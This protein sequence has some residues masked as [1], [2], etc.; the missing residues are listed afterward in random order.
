MVTDWHLMKDFDTD[1]YFFILDGSCC[2][3]IIFRK[4]FCPVVTCMKQLGYKSAK[5]Q[6][7]GRTHSVGVTDKEEAHRLDKESD[8]VHERLI[9]KCLACQGKCY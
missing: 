5:V 6:K 1:Q 9:E 2:H 8:G 7:K 4:F 3:N